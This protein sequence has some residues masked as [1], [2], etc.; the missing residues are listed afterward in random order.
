MTSIVS[1]IVSPTAFQ[2]F[3]VKVLWP[4]SMTIQGHPRSKM[5]HMG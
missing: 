5:M 1:N 3:A 4:I 2:I